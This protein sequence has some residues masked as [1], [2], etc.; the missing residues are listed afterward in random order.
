[1]A[2]LTQTGDYVGPALARRLVDE[3]HLVLHAP[4]ESL[5]DE[6]LARG[7][8]VEAV[9]GT[10]VDLRTEEGNHLLVER[11]MTRFGRIDAAALVTGMR[12]I[13]GR[14]LKISTQDWQRTKAENL[15]MAFHGLQSLI[16]TMVEQ[17]SGDIVL[18]TSATGARPEPGVSTYSATRAGANALV[19]A[20]G[21]SMPATVFASTP[22]APTSWISL[23]SFE[24][25]V[26]TKT[27]NAEGR[28][29]PRFRLV[30]SVPWRSWPSSPPSCS[31][32]RRASRLGSSSV[33]AGAGAPDRGQLDRAARPSHA[34]RV[35]PTE[36]RR[37]SHADRVT[38]TEQP[39]RVRWP[40][41]ARLRRPWP[42]AP[43]SAVGRRSALLPLH[44]AT[45]RAP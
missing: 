45:G 28:S 31:K 39:D 19:R 27:P 43:R 23:G 15:D 38:P 33:T 41:G 9:A 11:A 7:G 42:R 44:P 12:I 4:D 13:T 18:F 14:F 29:R 2:V 32:A 3:H 16:P 6:L 17:G 21:Q 25:V 24:P 20:V 8:Q 35:T 40:R 30:A 36:S 37:P 5:V 26:R 1:V 10:E 34:D 22:S